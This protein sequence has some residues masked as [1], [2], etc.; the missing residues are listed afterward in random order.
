MV[1][2]P[3]QEA[4]KINKINYL[5]GWPFDALQPADFGVLAS[6]VVTGSQRFMRSIAPR[7]VS[8]QHCTGGRTPKPRVSYG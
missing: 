4:Q 6:A 1:L 8:L 7:R 3:S 5:H 2:P